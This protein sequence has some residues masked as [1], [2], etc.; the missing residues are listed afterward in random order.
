M[1][2][3]FPALASRNFRLFWGGQF[4]SLIGTWMQ[5]TTLPYLAYRLSNQPLYLGMIGFAASIPGLLVTLPAGVYI[6]RLDKRK[7]VI[8]LQSLLMLQAFTLAFLALSGTITIWE[9]IALSFFNGTVSALEVS[10]RQAMIVELVGKEALPN[11]IALNSTI[12][13]AARV[14]GPSLSAPFLI[15]LQNRGEGWAFFANGVSYI[16]VIVGLMFVNSRSIIQPKDSTRTFLDDFREGQIFIRKTA[17][18]STL[19]MIVSIF[20]FFGFPFTQQIP[21]FARDV[22]KTAGDTEGAVATRN[23]LMV[24]AQGVGALIAAVTLATFSTIRRKGMALT[25][26]QVV[27]VVGLIGLSLA[28]ALPAVLLCMVMIGWGMVTAM[29]LTNTLIQLSV[30]D[31]LR[32]RVISTYFWAQSAVA[33][34]GSLFIGW[35]AQNWGAPWAV[36]TGGSVCLLSIFSIHLLKPSLRKVTA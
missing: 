3:R 24:T 16:F 19:I 28:R 2:H 4:I 31:N 14:L 20:G 7:A 9:I 15:L 27:F 30:P 18:I 26:G 17:V 35:L 13:N 10:V 34:F 29:A 25:I 5:S 8:I 11:A 36:L 32:G 6:E 12:F 33:P 23:S 21:V 22:L 1:N